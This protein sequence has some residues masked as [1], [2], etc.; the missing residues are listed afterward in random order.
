LPQAELCIL[1]GTDHATFSGRP[2]WLNPIIGEFLDR[3]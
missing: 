2:E 1:P 3:P